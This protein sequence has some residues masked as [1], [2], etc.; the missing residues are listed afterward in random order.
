MQWC[1]G[2]VYVV[3]QPLGFFWQRIL[4]S[5]IINKHGTFR[6]FATPVCVYPPP[7]LAIH[8]W[9]YA[10]LHLAPDRQPHQ[11]PTTLF[12]YRPDAL[13]AAQPTARKHWRQTLQKSSTV[14]QN[15]AEQVIV[16]RDDMPCGLPRPLGQTDGFR[17]LLMPPPHWWG[18]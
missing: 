2:G 1:I 17:H 9:P 15:A 10:N 14:K 16:W 4:T 13:P 11:H 3:Y 8:H 7:F 18:A 12:F 6:P 5:A